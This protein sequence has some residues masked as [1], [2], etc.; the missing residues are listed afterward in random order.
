VRPLS[1]FELKLKPDIAPN[2]RLL[3]EFPT[4]P[5]LAYAAPSPPEVPTQDLYNLYDSLLLPH[6]QSFNTTLYQ[7]PCNVPSQNKYSSVRT[8]T[9]CLAAYTSWLCSVVLP[10]CTDIPADQLPAAQA[11]YSIRQDS[12]IVLSQ[13]PIPSS[14]QTLLIRTD[15]ALSR[16]PQFSNSALA[17]STALAPFDPTSP[18]P[19][20]EVPPCSSVCNLVA[21]SCPCLIG[22]NCPLQSQTM[23]AAYGRL[24]S[25]PFE[26]LQG[27]DQASMSRWGRPAD[28]FG[29]VFCNAMGTDVLLAVR[30]S[31]GQ[32]LRIRTFGLVLSSVTAGWLLAIR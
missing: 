22:W 6:I 24:Q 15:P 2:C 25:L 29:N 9:D 27:G 14:L 26:A 4:C 1:S 10:R 17:N 30:T 31:G 16:T 19:Y 20:A 11:N 28:R 23:A 13:E 5:T 18:F 32:R 12:Q 7:F 3:F 8:C 21:A